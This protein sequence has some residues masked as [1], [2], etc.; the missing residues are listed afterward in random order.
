MQ[1]TVE[2]PEFVTE[3]S[4]FAA[5]ANARGFVVGTW[6]TTEFTPELMVE[7]LLYYPSFGHKSTRALAQGKA[8]N[9]GS[10]LDR[11]AFF[12]ALQWE[13]LAHL[14][15][16]MAFGMWRRVDASDY[17]RILSMFAD[18]HYAE[19]DYGLMEALV[20][21]APERALVDLPGLRF[22]YVQVERQRDKHIAKLARRFAK[23]KN[24]Q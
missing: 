21:S 10:L 5:H 18:P 2:E 8:Q 12:A 15:G 3:F 22:R 14:R 17:D 4:R 13:P 20:A 1:S 6:K 16:D 9:Y 11:T 24:A 19:C 23:R 7:F